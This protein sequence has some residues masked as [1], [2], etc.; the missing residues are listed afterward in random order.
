MTHSRGS[1]DRVFSPKVRSLF[2][3]AWG[4]LFLTLLSLVARFVAGLGKG[5]M[6]P[7]V[8]TLGQDLCYCEQFGDGVLQPVNAVSSL[9]IAAVGVLVLVDACRDHESPENRISAT[10]VY[11]I[12]Y[13][14]TAIHLGIASAVFHGTYTYWAGIL[15]STA[16]YFWLAFVLVYHLTGILRTS[17]RG[18]LTIWA[19]LS[20]LMTF[21]RI[22]IPNQGAAVSS[23]TFL[24]ASLVV[25]TLSVCAFRLYVT[26]P[27]RAWKSLRWL[28]ASLV[29]FGAGFCVWMKSGTGAVLCE[30]ESPLQGHA[31]WH[32]ASA[33]SVGFQ[34]IYLRVCPEMPSRSE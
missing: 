1:L 23:S 28:L 32:I 5:H 31:F 4:A 13:A 17:P 7:C 29:A 26:P 14:V 22:V 11:P 20:V 12:W 6:D 24:F 2:P 34:Y 30:P 33:A 9:S 10:R 21:L 15:D 19:A 27:L 18:A 3:L 25:A 16:M 8:S